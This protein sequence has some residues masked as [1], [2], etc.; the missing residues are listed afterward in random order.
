MDFIELSPNLINILKNVVDARVE[1]NAHSSQDPRDI[2]E[3]VLVCDIITQVAAKNLASF[4]VR[5]R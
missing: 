1:I 5:L 2:L 3:I 4:S